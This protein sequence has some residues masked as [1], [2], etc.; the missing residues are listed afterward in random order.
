MRIPAALQIIECI[1][2][3]GQVSPSNVFEECHLRKTK[4]LILIS[5]WDRPKKNYNWGK[6]R[7]HGAGYMM[8]E[9]ILV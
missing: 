8:S 6:A 2:F 9:L 7:G 4:T 1:V 3:M 5:F